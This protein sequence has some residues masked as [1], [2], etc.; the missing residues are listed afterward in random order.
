MDQ[1][2]SPSGLANSIAA[3]KPDQ[4]EVLMMEQERIRALIDVDV[5]ALHALMADDLVHIHSNGMVHDKAALINHVETGRAFRAIDR[6]PLSVRVTGDT[7]IMHGA[8]TNHMVVGG[9]P[10]LMEGMV[11]QVLRREQGS[12]R[13]A[14]FQFTLRS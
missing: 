7:A 10:R 1:A 14:H 5:P 2:P 8:I 9:N 3:A 4:A 13:F 11:T 12:W 6:G